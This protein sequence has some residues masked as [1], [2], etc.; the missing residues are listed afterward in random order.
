MMSEEL[1]DSSLLIG[2]H[3][4]AE[5]SGD[6]LIPEL[7]ALLSRGENH[8]ELPGAKVLAFPAAA[9]SVPVADRLSPTT[10][11]DAAGVVLH[12]RRP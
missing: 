3:K 9:K 10:V 1:R 6:G 2:L 11:G 12:M 4:L 7:Y 8:G 5:H